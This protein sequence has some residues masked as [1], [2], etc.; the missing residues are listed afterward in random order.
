MSQDPHLLH[1]LQKDSR[2]KPSPK[3]HQH[4]PDYAQNSQH[5][6]LLLTVKSKP[7]L[8]DGEDAHTFL[9][10]HE[11]LPDTSL[12]PV[13][14]HLLQDGVHYRRHVLAVGT[15][16]ASHNSPHG[17]DGFLDELLSHVLVPHSRDLVQELQSAILEL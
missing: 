12:V 7:L 15:V 4:I 9:D 8:Y 10:L 5:N 1:P 14:D 6:V 16:Q 17:P 11:K 2:H 3:P 13:C